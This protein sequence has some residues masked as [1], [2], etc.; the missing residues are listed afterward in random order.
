MFDNIVSLGY[1]CWP[2]RDMERLGFRSRSG[3]FDWV[4]S[5]EMEKVLELLENHFEGFLEYD[6]LYQNA[7]YPNIYKDVRY[8]IQ[9]N[10]DF[11]ERQSLENQLEAVQTK[12]KRRI[13]RFYKDIQVPTLFIRYI[14]SEEE[15][16][17]FEI[18][19]ENVLNQ[20]KSYNIR[21]EL[22]LIA[23]EDIISS[24]INIY[25]VVR[26][27]GISTTLYPIQKNAEL[28]NYIA[29]NYD[30]SKRKENIDFYEKKKTIIKNE[31]IR[32]N[33]RIMCHLKKDKIYSHT[34]KYEDK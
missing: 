10:H 23:H 33:E 17:Y 5:Y 11:S 2:A 30:E 32:W 12:Y 1:L 20:L 21:N 8:N 27:I 13:S 6:N 19:Y 26:D 4:I 24:N 3:P 28:Y 18:N 29:N 25:N 34:R 16:A 9:F 31:K 15:K 22:V 7:E 14:I